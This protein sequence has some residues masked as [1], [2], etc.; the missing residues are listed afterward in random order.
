[1]MV[2]RNGDAILP[3]L[4]QIQGE[5]TSTRLLFDLNAP[6]P[7][8]EVGDVIRISGL[9]GPTASGFNGD[10]PI[11]AHLDS[12]GRRDFRSSVAHTDGVS[13]TSGNN[14]ASIPAAYISINGI[15]FDDRFPGRIYPAD[16][17]TWQQDYVGGAEKSYEIN[18]AEFF[19]GASF[20][21]GTETRRSTRIINAQ[22]GYIGKSGRFVAIAG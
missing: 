21:A 2:L 1:M 16:R 5:G 3:N 12:R 11:T 17:C 13:A 14:E 8:L 15:P 20:T 19:D 4:F 18:N 10:Y 7:D 9:T 6:V 22:L